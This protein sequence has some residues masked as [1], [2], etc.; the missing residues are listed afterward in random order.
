MITRKSLARLSAVALVASLATAAFV[1]PRSANAQL[2][3]NEE[4]AFDLYEDGQL[5]GQVFREGSNPTEYVEHWVMFP[6]YIYPSPVN[7]VQ[8]VVVPGKSHYRGAADFLARVP[9]E[10]GSRY[11]RAAIFDAERIPGR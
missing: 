6:R 4:R 9:F 5:V 11:A 7:G 2:D 3:Y 10:P 1:T 8:L